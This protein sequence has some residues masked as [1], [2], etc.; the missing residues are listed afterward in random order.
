MNQETIE[1]YLNELLDD[2]EDELDR[3]FLNRLKAMKQWLA[4]LYDKY[5]DGN[6][7]S[8]TE[9]YKYRRFEKEMQFIK[10][11]I[12]E[13][14]KQAYALIYGLM[15]SQFVENY[16]RSG[17]VYEMTL[18]TD[19]QYAIPSA[20]TIREAVTN[21]I[22]ELTLNAT[23]NTH[24]NQVLRRIRIELGQGIQAGESYSQMA[25]RLEKAFNF[26]RNKAKLTAVTEAGRSQSKGRLRS[27]EK[28]REYAP[29]KKTDKLWLSSRDASVRHAH[30]VLD[31]QKAGKDDLFE[32][33]GHKAPA[34]SLF[35]I[36]RLDVRCRCDTLL[37]ID[38]KKP[39]TMRVRDYDDVQY[40]QRLAQRIEEIMA[41]EG[42]TEKQA[43][44]K[45]RK[46]IYPPSKVQDFMDYQT[47]YESL[48]NK[49]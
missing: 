18:A 14:Y 26:S 33:K 22:K 45:A 24:R 38:N 15:A 25:K 34:P 8:R 23:L 3:V 44:R 4:E 42:K 29:D 2:A 30:R 47:W 35:N 41:D 11:N 9:I 48:L 17:Y 31:G 20:E 32:Y 46:Q 27:V 21:P 10:A 37:L 40:Q 5:P 19:M 49:S 1:D 12:Q 13:D 7:I 36:A 43:T 16:I 28:V 39:D 6:G